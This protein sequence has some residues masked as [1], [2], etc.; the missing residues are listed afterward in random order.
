MR[1][2]LALILVSA[3]SLTGCE[4]YDLD[5]HDQLTYKVQENPRFNPPVGSVSMSPAR[6]DY[7]SV[8]GAFLL[9]PHKMDK[10][11][12]AEGQKLYDIYCLPCHGPDG[13]TNNTPV[14]D[15]FDPR[16]ANILDD[17]VMALTEGEIFQRI[18]DGSGV[19]PAYKRDLSDVEAW[20]VTAYV[21][22]L[23]KR[24]E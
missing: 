18:L 11:F 5:L 22:K 15:K 3:V 16:P 7:S 24:E 13:T 12:M 9:N 8:D 1:V 21:L 2:L 10:T 19:M 17:A 4:N 6:V 20:Q 23:Q 14:A